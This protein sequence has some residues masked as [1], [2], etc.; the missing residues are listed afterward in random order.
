MYESP[1]LAYVGADNELTEVDT[2]WGVVGAVAGVLG[3]SAAFVGYVCS[4]CNARS[5]WA[6]L[7]ATRKWFTRK[8]C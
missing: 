3:V 6:C 4:V 7:S 1:T 2:E 8:G 5:Y